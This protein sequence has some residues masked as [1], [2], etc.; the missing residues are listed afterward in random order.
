MKKFLFPVFSMMT[1]PILAQTKW[2]P[3]YENAVPNSKPAE[4]S[5]RKE[6]GN[7]TFTIDISVPT[8]AVFEAQ[9]PNGTAVII[10]PGGGYRGTADE[11]EGVAVAKK[12][13]ENGITAFVVRYR[14]PNDRYCID[15]TV[16]PLQDAQY[17]V[18]YVRRNAEKLHVQTNKIG[19]MGFSAGGHLAATAAT[20]YNFRAD[21]NDKDTTSARPDFAAL[22]YPVI[23]FSDENSV[24]AGSRENL[25]GKIQ[26]PEQ[27]KFL[28]P[29]LQ[30]TA[31]TPPTFLVHAGD[32]KVVKVQNSLAFYVACHEKGVSAELHIY[33][34][35]GHGFGMN[36]ATTKDKWIESFINWVVF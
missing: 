17:A 23:T 12:L 9:K 34:K 1:V 27:K 16:A 15:K 2:L 28:S 10:F 30:V 11:H 32:D 5:E 22:I 3:L 36:N 21:K 35:G 4:N 24:H 7:P 33:P 13:N 25:L 8:M 6:T 14:I 19:V 26:T 20:L 31:Q 18:R 29:E